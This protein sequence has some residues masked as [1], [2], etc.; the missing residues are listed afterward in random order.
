MNG[1]TWKNQSLAILDKIKDQLLSIGGRKTEIKN[2]YELWRI[3]IADSVFISFK[4]GTLYHTPSNSNSDEVLNAC[5]EIDNI[6]GTGHVHPTRDY[7]IGLDETGKGEIAGP[8]VLTGTIFHKN[9]FEDFVTLVGPADTKKQHSF[10]YWEEIYDKLD[11]FREKGFSFITETISAKLIDKYNVNHLLDLFYQ[12]IISRLLKSVSHK[13]CRIVL[14]DYGAGEDLRKLKTDDINEVLILPKAE[15]QFIEA[16]IASLISKK[17]REGILENINQLPEYRIDNLSIGNGNISNP[18]TAKWLSRWHASDKPWPWFIK[19]SF[20]TIKDLESQKTGQSDKVKKI[21]PNLRNDLLPLDFIQSLYEASSKLNLSAIKCS[22]C[23]QFQHTI[24][25]DLQQIICQ[26]CSKPMDDLRLTLR[27][28]LG[29]LIADP[30]IVK[31]KILIKDLENSAFFENY[32]VII[33][34]TESSKQDSQFLE[35]GKGMKKYESLGRFDVEYLKLDI[36]SSD[37]NAQ[38][39]QRAVE[40]NSM[41][42]TSSLLRRHGDSPSASISDDHNLVDLARK[43]KVLICLIQ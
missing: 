22:N 6:T 21:S 2:Q 38:I 1:R 35:G 20:K 13:G 24:L 7:L 15:D 26:S 27:Y 43:K 30:K 4:T 33:P 28:C 39:I 17:I 12:K 5:Q 23:N 40:S 36:D 16:K 8:I 11:Q 42:L 18:Q 19:Q 9:L 34:W 31:E 32:R 3:K 41:L 10:E 37:T 14:D 29:S 25:F